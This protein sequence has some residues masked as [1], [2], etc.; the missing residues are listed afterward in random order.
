MAV[1]DARE[2]FRGRSRQASYGDTPVYTRIFLVRVDE[3]NPDFQEISE[4]PGV[5]WLEPHPEDGEAVLIES[6]V[7]QDGD[8]PFHYKVTFTYKTSDGIA[9]IPWHR[10]FMYSFS[11]GLASA[12]AFW[13]F[14]GG[15]NDNSTK[16]IIHNTAGDPIAGLDRDEGEFQV[17]ITG[18][19]PPPFPY[20]KSQ[21]Y[22]GAINSDTWSGGAPKTWKCMSISASRKIESVPVYG[23][24]IY[25]EVNA[26]L[27]YRGS[28][29]DLQTWDVG[30]NQIIG[31][32]RFKILSSDGPVSEPVAL[33]NGVAKT[34]GLPPNQLTF[35]IYP[36][37]T[38]QDTFPEIPDTNPND[39]STPAPPWGYF[40]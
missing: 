2:M 1:V 31:G 30:F 4:A 9:E 36:M 3:L 37:R 12:P 34:P 21:A 16:S 8:S 18:N 29:W 11:G 7:S 13:Y 15:D 20:A 35:R 23:K 10:P 17:T 28:G 22:V 38:F 26:T 5:S 27:A 40:Q 19:F 33:Q 24:L 39:P 14:S 25:Y 6:N 32:Q